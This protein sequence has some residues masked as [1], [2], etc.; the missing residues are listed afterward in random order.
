MYLGNVRVFR[1]SSKGEKS[2]KNTKQNRVMY[3]NQQNT[4]EHHKT[5]RQNIVHT[6]TRNVLL[7]MKNNKTRNKLL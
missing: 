2:K 6:H 1:S 5:Y 4:D 3:P 7:I